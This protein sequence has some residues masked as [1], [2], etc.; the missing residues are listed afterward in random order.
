MNTQETT[1]ELSAICIRDKY[2]VLFLYPSLEDF[3]DH[4][5]W[6]LDEM[7]AD[8]EHD[9]EDSYRIGIVRSQLEQIKSLKTVEEACA[10]FNQLD[11]G[12]DAEAITQEE[13]DTL[14]SEI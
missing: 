10:W 6:Q 12:C 7:I 4:H 1:N 13:Y 5:I 9:D 11:Q 3:K 2:E 14:D 8:L